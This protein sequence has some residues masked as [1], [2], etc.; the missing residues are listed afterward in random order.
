M[1]YD[2]AKEEAII[3][4][5]AVLDKTLG[6]VSA[7]LRGHGM[8]TR[9]KKVD[10][11]AKVAVITFDDLQPDSDLVDKVGEELRYVWPDAPEMTA[12][13]FKVSKMNAELIIDL[14]SPSG[15]QALAE[16]GNVK[17][18]IACAAG[19]DVLATIRY[20]HEQ[21]KV[22]HEPGMMTVHERDL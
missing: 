3:A 10:Y 15:I 18:L 7:A 20:A 14:N 17:A 1:N 9:V 21:G 22:T 2:E 13:L 4:L 12:T 8:A 19:T 5:S 16:Q 11:V 6:I